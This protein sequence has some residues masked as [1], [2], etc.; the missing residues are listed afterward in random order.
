MC[1]IILGWRFKG[2]SH[3]PLSPACLYNHVEDILSMWGWVTWPTFTCCWGTGQNGYSYFSHRSQVLREWFVCSAIFTEQASCWM[4][5]EADVL[6]CLWP[7]TLC[8]V[9]LQT[10]RKPPLGQLLTLWTS[11]RTNWKDLVVGSAVCL[12]SGLFRTIWIFPVLSL[13]HMCLTCVLSW[14]LLEWLTWSVSQICS[15]MQENC[16]TETKIK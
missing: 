14:I 7:A 16:A 12:N 10:Q 9:M 15:E 3:Q 4:F 11:W 8:L 13:T 2:L 6:L 1:P 5:A